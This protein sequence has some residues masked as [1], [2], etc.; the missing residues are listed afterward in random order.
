MDAELQD[1]TESSGVS[2]LPYR[3]HLQWANGRG[4][5]SAGFSPTATAAR[6]FLRTT[7]MMTRLLAA[8]STRAT[9]WRSATTS[10]TRCGRGTAR[11]TGASLRGNRP[12]AD[13]SQGF[14][15]PFATASI[16]GLWP[17]QPAIPTPGD[18]IDYTG[19]TPQRLDMGFAYDDVPYGTQPQQVIAIAANTPAPHRFKR[20]PARRRIGRHARQSRSQ[21]TM[22]GPMRSASSAAG[23]GP[24][25]GSCH[26]TSGHRRSRCNRTKRVACAAA[27]EVLSLQMMF[28]EYDYHAHHAAIDA[29]H[30][31]LSDKEIEVRHAALRML[32]SHN[33]PELISKLAASLD[34]PADT[35]FSKVD[36]IRGW[37]QPAVLQRMPPA[38][39][40]LL[41]PMTMRFA[42]LPSLLWRRMRR[43]NRRSR[44]SWRI[45]TNPTASG[46][47]RSAISPQEIPGTGP[48]IEVLSNCRRR[49]VCEIRPHLPG[50]DDRDAWRGTRQ[51]PAEQHRHRS[52]GRTLVRPRGRRALQATERLNEKK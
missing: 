1:L 31:A 14:M 26:H 12:P 9:A 16:A 34:N 19:I 45:A 46:R 2:A 7:A 41:R 25:A 51:G 21:P 3:L 27:I 11:S 35:S 47:R 43:A 29:L 15:G 20:I 4:A 18:L 40:N 17:A 36:A 6:A 32:A 44:P 8:T 49:R 5:L 10:T 39:A 38:S 13:I 30:K 37:S 48:L 23:A 24:V 28:G 42:S 22:P 52:D 50:S 33:D